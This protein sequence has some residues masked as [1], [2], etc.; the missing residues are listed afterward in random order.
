MKDFDSAKLR[1]DLGTKALASATTLPAKA[2]CSAVGDKPVGCNA[3][4]MGGRGRWASLEIIFPE[5][6]SRNAR[7]K[8]SKGDK[9]Y[10]S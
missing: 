6:S 9:T 7:T 1:V 10:E 4:D 5:N 8:V 3:C 2:P